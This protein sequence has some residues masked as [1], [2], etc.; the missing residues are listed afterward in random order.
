MFKIAILQ[1]NAFVG[2]RYTHPLF[3]Q[4]GRD[5]YRRTFVAEFQRIHQQV[6]KHNLT[7]RLI[8]RNFIDTLVG[9]KLQIYLLRLELFGKIIDYRLD[10]RV[11]RMRQQVQRLIPH[12]HATHIQHHV[13]D[14]AH[15][16]G[17]LENRRQLCFQRLIAQVVAQQPFQRGIDK[18]K[19][20]AQFVAHVD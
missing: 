3:P 12:L 14:V 5:F 13:D 18:S 15:P 6:R 19:W 7:L 11:Q 17:L 2:N 10:P 20:C 9:N 1:A 16:P 4:L 8:E